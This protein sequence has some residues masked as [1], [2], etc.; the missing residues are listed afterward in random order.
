MPQTRNSRQIRIPLAKIGALRSLRREIAEERVRALAVLYEPSATADAVNA[1]ETQI[2][3]PD[4]GAVV[5][6]IDA[7]LEGWR[8]DLEA[9][10][11]Q[12][13]RHHERNRLLADGWRAMSPKARAAQPAKARA[14]LKRVAR[15]YPAD[16]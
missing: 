3:E 14:F 7:A 12:T 16:G 15:D 5:F 2:L 11:A 1:T 10:K 13:A 8:E 6:A 9:M 4:R